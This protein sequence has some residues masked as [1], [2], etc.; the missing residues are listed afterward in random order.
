MAAR[1]DHVISPTHAH[2][3]S[4]SDPLRQTIK[5]KQVYHIGVLT[6]REGT[7]ERDRETERQRERERERERENDQTRAKIRSHVD[8]DLKLPS[9]SGIY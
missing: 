1:Y 3:L 7:A 9:K 6:I 5:L 8:P 2:T 4:P